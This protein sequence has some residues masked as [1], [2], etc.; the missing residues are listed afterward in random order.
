[1]I[2]GGTLVTMIG[3]LVV[4]QASMPGWLQRAVRR[5]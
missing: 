2:L 1:M 5:G 4:N 3:V